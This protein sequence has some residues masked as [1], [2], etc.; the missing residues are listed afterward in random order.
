MELAKRLHV[1]KKDVN[2]IKPLLSNLIKK[3]DAANIFLSF[4]AKTSLAWLLLGPALSVN[5]DVY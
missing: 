4:F 2:E 1:E 3:T 5:I